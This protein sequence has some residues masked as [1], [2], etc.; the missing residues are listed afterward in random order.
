VNRTATY[1]LANAG[2]AVVV[3]IG[4]GVGSAAGVHLAYL[5]L[6]FALCSSVLLNIR[7]LNDRFALLAIFGAVYFQYFGTLDLI[8]LF[9]G[10]GAPQASNDLLSTAELVIL[11]GCGILQVGYRLACRERSA[12]TRQPAKDWPEPALVLFGCVLWV[13]STWLTWWFK[14][15]VLTDQ[16]GAAISSGLGRLSSLEII[17]FLLAGMLQP[18]SIL[19]LA[20]V[21]YRYQRKYMLP[22]IVGVVLVQLAIGFVIDVKGEALIGAVLVVLTRLLVSGRIPKTWILVFVAF[23]AVAFPALQANRILRNRMR[24]D[25]VAV[26]QNLVGAVKEA[27][28]HGE[29]VSSGDSRAQTVF[30]RTTLKGMVE[31]IVTRTGKDVKYQRGYTLTPIYAAFIPKIL[32]PDKPDIPTGQ[33]VNSE[34][35]V[36]N[37]AYAFTYISPSHLGELYWNFGWP[38]ALGGMLIIGLLLGLVGAQVDMTQSISLTRLMI[39]VVTIRLLI[40]GFESTVATQYVVWIRSLAAIGFLHLVLARSVAGPQ[41]VGAG[42]T[43]E[44]VREPALIRFPNLLR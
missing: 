22:L 11:A 14:V 8:S 32:W 40:L 37:A 27:F 7:R 9:R 16:N 26:A 18:L 10:T 38:G 41:G 19:M 39:A 5:L 21:Q 1:L 6:L 23:I 28:A 35:Q 17:G 13:I 30:E 31:M 15:Y 29:E 4:A 43:P 36:L 33:L 42:A 24:L 34:F 2:F 3:A 12:A 44:A 20:Y 25:H